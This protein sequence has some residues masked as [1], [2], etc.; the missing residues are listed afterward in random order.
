MLAKSGVS[1][2]ALYRLLW[3]L[4]APP[5]PHPPPVLSPGQASCP[6]KL[7]PTLLR[8]ASSPLGLLLSLGSPDC[9]VPTGGVHGVLTAVLDPPE[10]LVQA[11]LGRRVLRP[12]LSYSHEGGGGGGLR[13]SAVMDVPD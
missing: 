7:S 13:S 4:L 6:A 1:Q 9:P 12:R 8:E 10:V 5:H 11:A 3:D 2:E